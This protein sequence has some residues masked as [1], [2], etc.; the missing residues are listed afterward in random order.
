[1]V[2]KCSAEVARV[3]GGLGGSSWSLRA[4]AVRG[5]DL[6]PWFC[7]TLMKRLVVCVHWHCAPWDP[8]RYFPVAD[9]AMERLAE[10]GGRRLTWGADRYAFDFEP[11][12]F[13]EVVHVALRIVV[14]LVN[15]SV[16]IALRDLAFHKAATG[17]LCAGGLALALA[18]ALAVAAGP[19]QTLV[20]PD[21]DCRARGLESVRD[22]E[23]EVRGLSV[24]AATLIPG[25]SSIQEFFDAPVLPRPSQ[26]PTSPNGHTPPP[27]S[28]LRGPVSKPPLRATASRP[29][30]RL[31]V[32]TAKPTSVRPG[33]LAS[34]VPHPPRPGAVPPVLLRPS[35]TPPTIK[36]PSVTP[37]P[38][39]G[40]QRLS[41]PIPP[42]ATSGISEGKDTNGKNP[43]ADLEVVEDLEALGAVELPSPPSL[44]PPRSSPSS[45]PHGA[46]TS[47][48]AEP[49][50][51][52][53]SKAGVRDQATTES[54]T[55]RPS[56]ADATSPPEAKRS[57]RRKRRKE[58]ALAGSRNPTN[59]P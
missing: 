53:E 42:A 11:E 34:R 9:K 46:P 45:R 43:G 33:L 39:A 14:D 7:C 3:R 8:A 21:I 1:M 4:L 31:D 26:A 29:P 55:S 50:A 58:R 16:G 51:A 25:V 6:V 22:T 10:L 49:P 23:V 56:E 54:A 30:S 32:V 52:S 20:D 48:G 44:P 36:R 18:E 2:Q 41:T 40:S 5:V 12:A 37:S 35:A 47:D 17:S 38:A 24:R 15:H 28:A 59:G 57:R 13:D 19:G 27:P